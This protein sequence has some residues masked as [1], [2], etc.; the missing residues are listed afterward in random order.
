MSLA[1]QWQPECLK[2]TS[3]GSGSLV[4]ASLRRSFGNDGNEFTLSGADLS[5][6]RGMAHAT[7]D[8]TY[9]ALIRAIEDNGTIRVRFE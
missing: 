9:N 6:L 8:P 5:E 7:L 4:V 3:A 2:W 1:V